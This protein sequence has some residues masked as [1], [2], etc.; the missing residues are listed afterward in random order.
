MKPISC[1]QEVGDTER[2]SCPGAH[3]VLLSITPPTQPSNITYFA[4]N[5]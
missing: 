1:N 2:L 3:R 4:N 5:L